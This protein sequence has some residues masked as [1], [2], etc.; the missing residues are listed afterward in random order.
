MIVPLQ[1]AIHT[2]P[3]HWH[4]PLSFKPDRFIAEDGSLAKPR[5]FLPFQTGKDRKVEN[6]A[7]GGR[8]SSHFARSSFMPH[9]G[10]RMC[11]GDE[12]AKMMLFLFAARMLRSFVIS[13]PADAPVDL[14]GECGITLVPKPHRLVFTPRE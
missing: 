10:K 4:E 13:L 5:A 8:A 2:D 3:A 12:L 7:R 9:Q 1:W 6:G 14:E 11:V